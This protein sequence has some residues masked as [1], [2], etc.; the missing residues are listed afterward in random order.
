VVQA[1]PLLINVAWLVT[2]RK[3]G[4]FGLE[5]RDFYNYI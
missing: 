1:M 4:A 5:I 3:E 2:G